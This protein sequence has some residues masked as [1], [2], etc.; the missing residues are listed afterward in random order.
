MCHWDRRLRQG[1]IGMVPRPVLA[2]V[3]NQSK[4]LVHLGGAGQNDR[5]V[6][7]AM[8]CGAKPVLA[9]IE[10]HA[11][12]TYKNQLISHVIKD[13]NSIENIADELYH[14]LL[15]W[16]ESIPGKVSEY[17]DKEA[18]VQSVVIPIF[19]RLFSVMDSSKVADRQLLYNEY[20]GAKND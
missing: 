5:G 6:L 17:Y 9:N 10:Y 1:V 13:K 11:P 12:L 20:L 8:R 16:E 18:D 4:L 15:W 3:L 14:L 19:E 2:T 7:E